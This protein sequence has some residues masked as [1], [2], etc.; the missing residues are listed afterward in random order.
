LRPAADGIAS[1]IAA[2]EP[3]LQPGDGLSTSARE[4]A[5]AR[6]PPSTISVMGVGR[7]RCRFDIAE[8]GSDERHERVSGPGRASVAAGVDVRTWQ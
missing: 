1:T 6:P 5:L 4:S 2:A 8:D 3:Q 7:P